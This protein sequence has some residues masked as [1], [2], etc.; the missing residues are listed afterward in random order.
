MATETAG[1]TAPEGLLQVEAIFKSF[2]VKVRAPRAPGSRGTPRLTALDGV[3]LKLTGGQVLGLVGESGSG[4]ST[5][6]KCLVRLLDPDR[7][8]VL[9]R[10]RDVA[11]A[12][13][14]QLMAV[15]R[16]MQ[17]IY[18][19]PYASLN[20]LIAVGEAIAEPA[21]VH[22]LI[23]R[24][25][26]RRF[27]GEMLQM[28]GLSPETALRRPAELSGGQRQRVAIARAM[29]VQPDVLIADEAIS[30][31]DVSA[32][33]QI[34]DLLAGLREDRGVGILLISHQLPVV[35]QIADTV[36]IVYL[37]RIVESG[38][39]TRVFSAPGHP[40]THA[41][42]A[43]QPGAHRRGQRKV[44]ALRGEI[45]SPLAIPSGCRFRTRCPR[46]EAICAALDPPRV[47]L[48]PGHGAWCHFAG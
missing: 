3:S 34:L 43:A 9:Y 28:V 16:A 1:L 20:P 29:A 44:P 18:Q 36:A 4:K 12:R 26:R 25:E 38:P 13:G 8:R 15:R 7:G 33:A 2:H 11:G 22:S 6:A 17:L 30:S 48:G 47:E 45:P 41:L 35:A 39:A 19:N 46:A 10:G 23:E 31:L 32:Q 21:W 40:Y 27:A 5:L 42:L 14:P 24:R 37:G